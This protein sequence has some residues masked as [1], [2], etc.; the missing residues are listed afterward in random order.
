[1]KLGPYLITL[2]AALIGA[3]L[4]APL[5][6]SAGEPVD[7]VRRDF[8][9]IASRLTIGGD[10][11][12]VAN[13]R[14]MIKTC[15]DDALIGL[16]A[17]G[18]PDR[19]QIEISRAL[20]RTSHFLDKHGFFAINGI[21]FSSV[22]Q[23]DGRHY[24]KL[25]LARDYV[26]SNL[27]LWRGLVGWHP[28]RISSLDYLPADIDAFQAHL[29]EA[30]S[31]WQVTEQALNSTGSE[32]TRAAFTQ[33]VAHATS[34]LGIAPAD[35]FN[36]VRDEVMLAV[37]LSDKAK[38]V[39]PIGD[40]L[41]TL[42]EAEF[43][44]CIA[45][46]GQGLKHVLEMQ[47]AALGIPLKQS[48][49]NDI[50][51]HSLASPLPSPVP[52]TLS[53]AIHDRYCLIGSSSRIL[54]N[55]IA[56]YQHKNGL[57]SRPAFRK[58]FQGLPM[59]NNGMIYRNEAAAAALH[60][61]RLARRQPTTLSPDL[62]ATTLLLQTA[63]RPASPGSTAQV[64][65]NWKSGIMVMGRTA[66]SGQQRFSRLTTAP[67]RSW[68]RAVGPE[69]ASQSLSLWGLRNWLAR[70]ATPAPL[71]GPTSDETDTPADGKAAS[72]D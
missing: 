5:H 24:S 59:V 28:R 66:E 56:A 30:S 2:A 25:F 69:K 31:L 33:L 21:G 36:S 50:T 41:V 70:Q 47:L 40:Q 16:H 60:K 11:Y 67:L 44:I 57:T 46:R 58:A 4:L 9:E 23:P 55:A 1:M 15:F 71:S 32:G 8:Q 54:F 39:L 3:A 68:V 10:F 6:T 65:L 45:M 48:T 18:E 51:I 37:R 64:V 7:P 63:L 27:S 43:L 22:P 13:T 52:L 12:I 34:V 61:I 14:T 17:G 72:S 29:C 35:L 62:P 26:D 42:P 49:V 53:Y 19:E 20:T 38:M